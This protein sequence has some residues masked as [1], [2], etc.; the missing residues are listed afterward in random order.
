MV[1]SDRGPDSMLAYQGGGTGL[2]EMIEKI[3][4]ISPPTMTPDLVIFID[5]SPEVCHTRIEARN[6]TR[7]EFEL[8]D[9]GFTKRVYQTFKELCQKDE[10]RVASGEQ[11]YPRYYVFDGNL[12]EKQLAS[13]VKLQLD[14]ILED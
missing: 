8:R 6:E 14:F 11:R 9:V 1:L 5:A 2:T 4:A 7:D 12:N 13:A 3:N 10:E